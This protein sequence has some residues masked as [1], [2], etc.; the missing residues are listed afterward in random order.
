MKFLK[1]MQQVAEQMERATGIFTL[2]GP[3]PTVLGF[4]FAPGGFVQ[5]ALMVNPNVRAIGVTLPDKVS[6][7]PVLIQD[8]RLTVVPA[9]VRT[10]Q[11]LSTFFAHGHPPFP[12]LPDCFSM[13]RTPLLM[14][15]PVET[16][17]FVPQDRQL[18]HLC[19]CRA[20]SNWP[21]LTPTIP[22]RPHGR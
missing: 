18:D 21:T 1:M 12:F 22:D 3:R 5:K 15:A 10:P 7:I 8:R 6:G 16:R 2:P 14:Y 19:N 20:Y 9:D 13:T 11:I 4:G 17:A